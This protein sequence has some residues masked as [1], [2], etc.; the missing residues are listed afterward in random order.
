[1]AMTAE[2]LARWNVGM[3]EQKLLSP[4]SYRQMQTEVLLKNGLGIS[5]GLGLD[6]KKR[7]G[8]RLLEHGGEV[9]GF[10]AANLVFPDDGAAVTVLV[11]QDSIDAS[12][13]IAGKIA[14]L[15]FA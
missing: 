6:V 13:V 12:G 15:L 2:D 4:G 10:T 14:D 7:D 8:R 5:Y 1:L 11:N 9:S 3:L